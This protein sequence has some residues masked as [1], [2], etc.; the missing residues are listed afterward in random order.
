MTTTH[1]DYM[2]LKE[3]AAE[4]AQAAIDGMAWHHMLLL[5]NEKACN[6]KN[7]QLV[8]SIEENLKSALAL[9]KYMR[10]AAKNHEAE[11]EKLENK[12][13]RT[14][15]YFV[16]DGQSWMVEPGYTE[17]QSQYIGKELLNSIKSATGGDKKEIAEQIHR[18]T[19]EFYELT[20]GFTV[21]ARIDAFGRPKAE[22]PAHTEIASTTE[23]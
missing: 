9:T 22:W 23:S 15:L 12:D 10:I 5:G 8:E 17:Q 2:A 14:V 6:S 4:K 18:K 1:N 16:G 19:L 7:M 13:P 20:K 3:A 11:L 21:K